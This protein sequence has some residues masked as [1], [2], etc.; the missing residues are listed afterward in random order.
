MGSNIDDDAPEHT[1]SVSAFSIG[2]TDVTYAEWNTVKT[3][4]IAHGYQFYNSS[5]RTS[6]NF[7]DNSDNYAVVDVSWYDAVKWCNAK[8]E[9][10][11]L[12]PVYHTD[13]TFSSSSVYR[14]GDIVVTNAMVSWDADGYR[15]PTEAEWEKAARGGLIGKSYP[16]GDTLTSSDANFDMNAGGTRPVKSYAPNGY[17]LYDMAGNVSQWCWDW[18]GDY[19]GVS[20]PHGP[21]AGEYRVVRGGGM[22]DVKDDCRVCSRR[23]F[24]NGTPDS[25]S[26]FCGFRVVRRSGS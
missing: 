7:E 10:Q 20:N 11:G 22:V 6:D 3:W 8:S 18:Y 5:A 24:V 17:G 13:A 16:N 25:Y 2:K 14:V 9:M 23:G 12:T 26:F 4:G 1:V 19:S 21:D 15:L